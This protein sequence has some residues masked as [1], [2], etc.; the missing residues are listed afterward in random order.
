MIADAAPDGSCWA[1]KRD[2]AG[3]WRIVAGYESMLLDFLEPMG[4]A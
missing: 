4:R 2:A 3:C 1:L